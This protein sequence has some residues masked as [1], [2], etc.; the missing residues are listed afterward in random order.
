MH[1][2]SLSNQLISFFLISFYC[3][4][5]SHLIFKLPFNNVVLIEWSD[6]KLPDYLI[7]RGMNRHCATERQL[8][9]NLLLEAANLFDKGDLWEDAI[10]I[11]KYEF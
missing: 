3:F 5:S 7:R 1:Q 2:L 4:F 10:R 6:D 8:K 11:L 9:E